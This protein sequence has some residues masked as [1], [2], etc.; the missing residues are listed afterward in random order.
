MKTYITILFLSLS[1]IGLA[2]KKNKEK[3]DALKI[4]HITSEVNLT[5]TEAEKF[6]P[7]YNEFETVKTKIRKEEYNAKRHTD[8]EKLSEKEAKTFIKNMIA[9]EEEKLNSRKKF[10]LKLNE[11]LSAKKIIKFIEAE[12][13]FKRKMIE[14][15]K[16]RMRDRRR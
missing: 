5:S 1:F 7:I 16:G 3:I 15:Y 12:H 4:A 9:L 2:Q 6:W 13:S 8:F 14:E 10:I 11:V